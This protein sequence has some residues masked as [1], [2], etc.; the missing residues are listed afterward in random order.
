MSA[1]ASRKYYANARRINGTR[2]HTKYGRASQHLHCHQERPQMYIKTA[3]LPFIY[4]YTITFRNDCWFAS[5][6]QYMYLDGHVPAITPRTHTPSPK[7][8]PHPFSRFIATPHAIPFIPAESQRISQRIALHTTTGWLG[9]TSWAVSMLATP[10]I[11][12]LCR[13]KSTRLTAVIGGLVLAL[14]I[15]FTSFATQLHQVAFS[16][17]TCRCE[18]LCVCVYIGYFGSCWLLQRA[19]PR[20]AIGM[21]DARLSAMRQP[22]TQH[23]Q[24]ERI[25]SNDI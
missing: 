6:S 4:K 14:G 17:G 3:Y 20:R 24:N 11:V 18:G 7:S 9:A 8:N 19:E 16:Y 5:A 22:T 21:C 1:R 15:L 13:R 2:V 12:A 10:V 23:S 25:E